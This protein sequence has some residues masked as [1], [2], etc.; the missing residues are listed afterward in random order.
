MYALR[1]PARY[2]WSSIAVASSRNREINK[3]GFYITVGEE[4]FELEP[5]EEEEEEVDAESVLT[6]YDPD[7][8]VS[9][10]VTSPETTIPVNMFDFEYPFQFL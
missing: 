10:A 5:E 3:H 8:F 2:L 1:C 4:F 9:G 6:E 7:D